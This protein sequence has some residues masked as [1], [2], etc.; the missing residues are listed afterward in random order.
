VKISDF[1]LSRDIQDK[2]YYRIKNS[3]CELP[4]KWMSPES[5][6]LG[7]FDSKSDVWSYGVV[8][9][10]L[11]TRGEKPYPLISTYE[12]IKNHL[13]GGNRLPK[14]QDCPDFLYSVLEKCWSYKSESRPDFSI[15]IIQMQQF[16]YEIE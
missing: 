14:P 7:T 10:E 2:D 15:L 4:I 12:G 6:E 9:W 1:G 16:L 3:N 13:K 5:L 8:V 11:L